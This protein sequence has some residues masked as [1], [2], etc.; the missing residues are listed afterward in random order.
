M[1]IPCSSGECDGVDLDFSKVPRTLNEE[2]MARDPYGKWTP[3]EVL[4][5]A[6]RAMDSGEVEGI[7]EAIVIL[8]SPGKTPA[9]YISV[10]NMRDLLGTLE[11]AKFE[12]RD[13]SR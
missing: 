12:I 7:E 3:R 9:Y 2:R 1:K 6:L 13:H 4:I 10:G 8:S 5:A 11:E